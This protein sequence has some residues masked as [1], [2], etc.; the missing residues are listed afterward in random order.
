MLGDFNRAKLTKALPKYRQQIKCATRE[1]TTL[2]EAYHAIRRAPLG[3][4]DHSI[5]FLLPSYRSK[6]KSGKPSVRYV[7]RWDAESVEAL[8][9]CLEC[10]LGDP[11]QSIHE[12]TEAVNSYI[13]FCEEVCIATRRVKLFP[14]S[15]PWFTPGLRAK[16]KT[17]AEAFKRCDRADYKKAK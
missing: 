4:S 16:L 13:H 11:Y 9:G 5:V 15:K 6:L 8:K 10:T 1:R 17:R 2:S 14:N 3:F 7:K 12:Y